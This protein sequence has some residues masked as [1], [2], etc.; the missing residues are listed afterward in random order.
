MVFADFQVD[1]QRLLLLKSGRPVTL[2][3]FH[4]RVLIELIQRPFVDQSVS[5]LKQAVWGTVGV[6]VSDNSVHQAI[7][8]ISTVLR[9]NP[10]KPRFIKTFPHHT[11]RWIYSDAA[12][13]STSA[14]AIYKTIVIGDSDLIVVRALTSAWG[15]DQAFA[16]K[17]YRLVSRPVGW[18][19]SILTAI[20][21]HQ[22]DIAV[23]NHERTLLYL[24]RSPGSA[25]VT[26]GKCFASMKGQNFYVLAQRGGGGMNAF[27]RKTYGRSCSMALARELRY[28]EIATCST[29]F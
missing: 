18:S 15:L 21:D 24:K 23:F 22:L 13:N 12:V 4:V 9:D 3:S 29:I 7:A 10:K 26:V 8:A 6:S 17:G 14:A 2:S 1:T 19:D 25:I 5:D 20:D 27:R 11:Y 16:E 28:R